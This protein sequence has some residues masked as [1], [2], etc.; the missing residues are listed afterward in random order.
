MNPSELNLD[1][2]GSAVYRR[3]GGHHSDFEGANGQC[4]NCGVPT[5]RAPDVH[6]DVHSIQMQ[7]T[8]EAGDVYCEACFFDGD[9]DAVEIAEPEEVTVY[10]VQAGSRMKGR[11]YYFENYQA[12]AGLARR[13]EEVEYIGA[14]TMYKAM[15]EEV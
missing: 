3:H 1:E 15:L 14:R 7:Y 13:E 8:S 11:T 10:R 9:L 5:Y 4:A 2:Y 12:A 6:E